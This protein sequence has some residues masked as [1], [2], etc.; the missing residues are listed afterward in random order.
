[1]I[2]SIAPANVPSQRVAQKLGSRLLGPGQLPPP[3]E[4]DPVELWGQSRGLA[5]TGLEMRATGE[6]SGGLRPTPW[7]TSMFARPPDGRQEQ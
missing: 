7:Y 2:H 1:M 3:Y 6:P 4:H 5:E